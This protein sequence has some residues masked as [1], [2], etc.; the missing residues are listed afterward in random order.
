[1]PLAHDL[2]CS[3]SSSFI[4]FNQQNC[5]WFFTVF[6]QNNS[7][8]LN[9]FTLSLVVLYPTLKGFRWLVKVKV[10][11]PSVWFAVLM[12]LELSMRVG[13]APICA[14]G[15]AGCHVPSLADLFDRVTQ[16][17]SRLHGISS[18][19]HSEFVSSFFFSASDIDHPSPSITLRPPFIHHQSPLFELAIFQALISLRVMCVSVFAGATFLSQQE[20]HRKT[21]VPHL[22]HTNTRG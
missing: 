9:T 16:Q 2:M 8:Q 4:L 19:L 20:P 3:F 21:E 22:W 13:T 12:Y 1:M 17:S 14:Y 6:E 15:Q 11:V 7:N 18:D 5:H 10:K